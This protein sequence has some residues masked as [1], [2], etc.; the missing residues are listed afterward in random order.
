MNLHLYV[1]IYTLL[2]IRI[3]YIAGKLYYEQF[4]YKEKYSKNY[5]GFLS[6][7]AEISRICDSDYYARRPKLSIHTQLRAGLV[8]MNYKN[9]LLVS[10]YP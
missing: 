2:K 8:H 7:D 3:H 4:P 1:S 5:R 6:L 10:S 9:W